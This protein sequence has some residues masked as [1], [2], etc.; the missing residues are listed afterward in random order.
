MIEEEIKKRILDGIPGCQ[1]NVVVSGNRA[2]ISVVSESF[3]ELN[4]VQR[5]QA[6]YKYVNDYISEGALHAVTVIATAR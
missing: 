2:E 6:I 5:D 4:R 3:T 1:V